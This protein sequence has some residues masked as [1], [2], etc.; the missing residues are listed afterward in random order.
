MKKFIAILLVAMM[1]LSM[2]ACGGKETEKG[3]EDTI[4][5]GTS[6]T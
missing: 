1:A 3:G 6:L 5:I 2:V 4:K